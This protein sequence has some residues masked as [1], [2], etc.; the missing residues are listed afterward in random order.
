MRLLLSFF[1]LLA[2]PTLV[3][4]QER[5][6]LSADASL[7]DLAACRPG[8]GKRPN[9]LLKE[10][11]PYL[12]EHAF[13]P[14]DWRP[15]GKS[16]FDEAKRRNVPVFVSSGYSTCHWCHVMHR[17]SFADAATAAK[18]NATF[19]CVKI[20]R[21]ELPDVDEAL[22]QAVSAFQ[23]SAGWPCT[24]ILEPGGK[25]FFGATYLPREDLANLVGRVNEIWS[26]P[27]KRARVE[28]DAQEIARRL[29]HERG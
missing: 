14:V 9:A 5:K 29:V 22:I 3:L 23:V 25:P 6:P 18:L 12:R 11:S 2:L 7:G 28:G 19:V 27:E 8:A 24:V 4:A 17:E 15:W 21:E 1:I 10:K 13:D 26:D 16:A 20:D